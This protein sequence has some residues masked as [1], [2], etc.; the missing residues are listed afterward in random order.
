MRWIFLLAAAAAAALIGT[1]AWLASTSGESRWLP[2]AASGAVVF[3]GALGGL[4]YRRRRERASRS[5]GTDSVERALAALVRAATRH[6]GVEPRVVVNGASI[7]L[8]PVTEAAAPI[9]LGE[10]QKDLGAA[11]AVRLVR[12]LGGEVAVEAERLTVSL[13][14]A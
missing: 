14:T 11:V 12:A 8:A 2:A 7:Q 3:A 10:E 9:V 13:P 6:G 1:S 5:A 4:A